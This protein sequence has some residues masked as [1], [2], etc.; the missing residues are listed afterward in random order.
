VTP[1]SADAAAHLCLAAGDSAL[2]CIAHLSRCV[3][4]IAPPPSNGYRQLRRRMVG[5]GRGHRG[6]HQGARGDT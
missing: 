4:H 6:H 1:T 2:R 5:A 3:A